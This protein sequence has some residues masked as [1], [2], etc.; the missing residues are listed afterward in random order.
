MSTP[1]DEARTKAVQSTTRTRRAQRRHIDLKDYVQDFIPI[2][3]ITHGIIET[4]DKRYLK[5]LEIEPINF[6]LRSN[7]EQME[8]IYNFAGWFKIANIKIQFKSI[9][10]KAD[11]ER[12]IS[13]LKKDMKDETNPAALEMGKAYIKLIRDVAS[14]DALTRHFYLIMEYEPDSNIAR[15][16]SFNDIY[17]QLTN[18]A[19]TAKTYLAQCGNNIIEPSNED[20]NTAEILYGF[21]NRRTSIDEP[22]QYRVYRVHEDT[23]KAKNASSSNNP[24]APVEPP[25]VDYIAPRGLDISH[26]NYLIM[27]GLYYTFLYIKANGYNNTVRCG[28]MS[29][30]VNAGDGI[31]VDVFFHKEDKSKVLNKISHKIILNT[32]KINS[33]NETD[34]GFEEVRNAIGS[35]YFIKESLSAGEDL[36]YMSTIITINDATLNGLMHKKR[37]IINMLKS[38]DIT[39]GDFRFQQDVAL[40]STMPLLNLNPKIED[41]IK[42]N[43][44]TSSAASTY[45]F[46]SFEMCDD[47][48]IL[49]GINEH[50]S[51]LC[52]IDLFNSKHYKNA[53]MCILGTSGSGKTFTEQLMALRMRMRGIQCFIIAPLKGHEFR[54][55]CENVGGTYI[56]ISPSS[57]HCINVMAIRPI[58]NSFDKM[59]EGEENIEEES[60]LARKIEQL[61]IFFRLLVPDMSNEEEQLL[62]ESFVDVYACKGITHD[63]D[64][65]YDK[66]GN[67]KEMPILSD[68]YDLLNKRPE[69]RRLSIIL[70]RFTTGSAQTFN[71]QTNV[72]LNNK[73]IV[74]DISELKGTL[75]PVGMFIALDYVWD[76]TKENRTQKKAIFIDETWLLIGSS[77]NRYAAEFVLEIFKIIRGYGGAAIAATQDLTDFFAL[78]DGKYGKGIINNSK[79]KILLNMERDE[80]KFVQDSMNLSESEY[81][82]ILHFERGH[83]LIATNNNKFP[84]IIKASNKEKYLITTDAAELKVAAE[85]RMQAEKN[86]K[87]KEEQQNEEDSGLN[88]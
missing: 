4:T 32:T 44:L 13:L 30:L 42:R 79:T 20:I 58:D 72:D 24:N 43:V 71:Q 5:I 69:T 22:F 7:E 26:V 66:N 53:N 84:V 29:S 62:D 76:K 68:L 80:A 6:L 40:L 52:I 46:T 59:L 87:A 70:S 56:K 34:N 39:C 51:S 17:V 41:K 19:A 9:T 14:K 49:L 57:S 67:I 78:E 74:M 83:G 75:L 36:Y 21:F 63:N 11:S 64:S 1:N 65:L 12:Y 55:A 2:K 33:L 15:S 82:K 38:Q 27:D 48:G 35:G 85:A 86:K 23:I 60:A 10:K 31:D 3:K 25:V 54:R 28:W 37:Q 47:N 50:N 77:S 73:Y 61:H 8:I 88:N 16:A 45:M 18:A 81:Q